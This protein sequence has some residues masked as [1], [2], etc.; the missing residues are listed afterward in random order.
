MLPGGLG[1]LHVRTV[2]QRRLLSRT[3]LGRRRRVHVDASTRTTGT[4]AADR[5]SLRNELARTQGNKRT[6]ALKAAV[7]TARAAWQ[8]G[9]IARTAADDKQDNCVFSAA[10]GH[11]HARLARLRGL[12]QLR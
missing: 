8:H 2:V 1:L 5:R 11:K 4:N 9:S 12:A 6:D 7:N 3:R 10:I